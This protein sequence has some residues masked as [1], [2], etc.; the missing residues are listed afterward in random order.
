MSLKLLH[1]LEQK[2]GAFAFY[3]C[4]A[5]CGREGWC[6]ENATVCELADGSYVCGKY[7]IDEL[8]YGDIHERC[9]CLPLQQFQLELWVSADIFYACIINPFLKSV[10]SFPEKSSAPSPPFPSLP[11]ARLSSFAPA[12]VLRRRASETYEKSACLAV[13]SWRAVGRRYGQP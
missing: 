12:G 3:G 8:P 6:S 1:F 4:L 13:P 7:A 10:S 11:P 5:V 2:C 9:D